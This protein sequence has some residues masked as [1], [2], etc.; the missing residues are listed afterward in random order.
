MRRG[1]EVRFFKKETT[2][3]DNETKDKAIL[4]E[5]MDEVNDPS[6]EAED[7][8]IWV[9]GYKGTDKNMRCRD[10]QYEIG[11]QFDMPD[12][13]EIKE[14]S[15][16]FHLCLRKE[17][18]FSYY[19][20]GEGN[21]FFKVKALVR[22]KDHDLYGS[23]QQCG[24]SCRV[25]DKI[26][27][28]SIILISELTIDEIVEFSAVKELPDKY[29][30]MAIE[31]SEGIA[32][33]TYTIDTLIQDGYSETFA[34]YLIYHDKFNVA[35]AVGTQKDLSMDMKVMTIFNAQ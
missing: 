23:Y 24:Y 7:E 13:E 9:E 30:Q 15:S 20:I 22:K 17:H 12:D 25:R 19:P 6:V 18:V 5:K 32:Y 14:C 33:E 28:K 1:V 16:G 2:K 4:E 26:T 3:S 29:K 11:K 21:R 27:S 31:T 8:W 10:Y 34:H 35:H